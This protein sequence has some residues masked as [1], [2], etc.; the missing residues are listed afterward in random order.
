M[1]NIGFAYIVIAVY[2]RQ[3]TNSFADRII[4]P[5]RIAERSDLQLVK[6][7]LQKSPSEWLTPPGGNLLGK[8][9]PVFFSFFPCRQQFLPG[10]SGVALGALSKLAAFYLGVSGRFFE[11]LFEKPLPLGCVRGG[12]DW[13]WL[14]PFVLVDALDR[15][16]FL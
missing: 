7:R 15:L 13:H 10:R 5:I 6:S 9:R 12:L 3:P 11:D 8:A 14:W 2:I 16:A 4:V 1:E